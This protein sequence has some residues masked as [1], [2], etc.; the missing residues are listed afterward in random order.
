MARI[1]PRQTGT[2]ALLSLHLPGRSVAPIG[3]ILC[4]DADQLYVKLRSDWSNIAD[5]AEI[6]I[7]RE[8]AAGLEQKGR[9]LGGTGVLDRLENTASHAIQI[10]TQTTVQ[11]ADPNIALQALYQQHVAEAEHGDKASHKRYKVYVAIAAAL[12]ITGVLGT[13]WN[14]FRVSHS[15]ISVNPPLL[16]QLPHRSDAPLDVGSVLNRA[17]ALHRRHRPRQRIA[18]RTHRVFQ[19]QN[20]PFKAP[21]KHGVEIDAPPSY[22]ITELN[23]ASLLDLSL[24]EPPLFQVRRNRFVHFLAVVA[25]SV[26]R[27]FSSRPADETVFN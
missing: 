14:R 11:V 3:I 10:G 18:A 16:S 17:S 7:C 8:L 13:Q 15:F 21:A 1:F 26:R 20:M 5:L 19:F 9:E 24:P 22:E 23:S 2:W 6:E 12:I 27:V 25:S 4:D